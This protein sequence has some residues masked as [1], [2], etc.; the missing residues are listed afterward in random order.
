MLEEAGR[1]RQENRGIKYM[2]RACEDEINF[3]VCKL[4][5][6]TN[7]MSAIQNHLNYREID[8]A[9]EKFEDNIATMEELEKIEYA[10]QMALML[11]KYKYYRLYEREVTSFISETLSSCLSESRNLTSSRFQMRV[12]LN[13]DDSSNDSLTSSITSFRSSRASPEL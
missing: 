3:I 7:M 12:R 1:E 2:V 5:G 10:E 8:K 11:S 6:M 9:M 4:D 13:S